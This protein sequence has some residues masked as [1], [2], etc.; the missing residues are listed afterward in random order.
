MPAPLVT[1]ALIEGLNKGEVRVGALLGLCSVL[2]IAGSDLEGA[3]HAA[4]RCRL[5]QRRWR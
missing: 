1:P 5:P 3:R 2:G 4:E